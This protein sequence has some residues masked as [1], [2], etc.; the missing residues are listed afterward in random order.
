MADDRRDDLAL[1]RACADGSP[2]AWDRFVAMYRP[3]LYAAAR[4]IAGDAR[5]R[6]LADSL[7]AD[8]YGV[9]ARGGR[10][11]SLF[12]YYQG[13]SSLM[14]WLRAV[15]AQ[16]HVD[17]LRVERRH[18]SLDDPERPI[19]IAQETTL[20]R[21]ETTR[22]SQPD[23]GRPRYIAAL[24]IAVREALGALDD[25][26]R[27]TVAWYYGE[28]LTLAEIARLQR[29]HESSVSR[30]LAR[31]RRRVRESV[32]RTLRDRYRF[33]DAQVRLA[34]EYAAG[35]MAQE[36]ADGTFNE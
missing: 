29:E 7:Y 4:A 25:R 32:E 26:D 36:I 6:E 19:E 1:A 21:G 10:R 5:G 22:A 28:G 20:E 8:L 23:P 17:V 18:T 24:R 35:G 3:R 33:D 14:T 34:F 9:D 30:R 31:L 16:R 27:L 13:R 12:T 15:L 11:R 2:E